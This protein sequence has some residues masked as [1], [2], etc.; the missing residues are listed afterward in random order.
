MH[1]SF[2][3]AALGG[4]NPGN[5]DTFGGNAAVGLGGGAGRSKADKLAEQQSAPLNQPLLP[6]P[7]CDSEGVRVRA[8]LSLQFDHVALAD[9]VGGE[10]SGQKK[11]AGPVSSCASRSPVSLSPVRLGTFRG[12]VLVSSA[13]GDMPVPGLAREGRKSRDR[14]EV[15]KSQGG[16]G[17]GGVGGGEG[18]AY[19]AGA[20]GSGRDGGG[21]SRVRL[22]TAS[23]LSGTC[24]DG[25]AASSPGK[26]VMMV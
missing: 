22:S 26:K 17:G 1:S 11:G 7:P 14:V 5:I 9:G 12:S 20:D 16:G 19:A 13:T 18:A 21:V 24:E 8:R 23:G 10:A 15:R 2:S 3:W 6:P 4:D 25:H